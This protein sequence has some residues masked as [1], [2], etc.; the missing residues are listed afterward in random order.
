MPTE[1]TNEYCI[2]NPTVVLWCSFAFLFICFSMF[3]HLK[4]GARKFPASY[5]ALKHQNSFRVHIGACLYFMQFGIFWHAH[6]HQ[7]WASEFNIFTE[8]F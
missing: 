4:F 6:W 1:L 7:H 5:L 2:K 3:T 8:V